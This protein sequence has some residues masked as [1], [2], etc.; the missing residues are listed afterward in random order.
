MT[1]QSTDQT[2]SYHALTK[3]AFEKDEWDHD[4]YGL[5][6]AVDANLKMSG[7]L[8]NRPSATNAPD[9]A[10]YEATDES[11]IYRNDPANGWVVNGFGTAS[12]PVPAAY[13]DSLT[14]S[15]TAGDAV[16]SF[17]TPTQAA[18]LTLQDVDGEF[19]FNTPLNVNGNDVWT[20]GNF[21]PSSKLSTTN[22]TSSG[23]FSHGGNFK[24]DFFRSADV[25]NAS[26]GE[27]IVSNGDGTFSMEGVAS[28]EAV[29]VADAPNGNIQTV[30]LENG[31]STE[32]S[33]TVP[34]GKSLTVYR[35]GCYN[36]SNSTAPTGLEVQLL[37]DD[38]TVIGSENTVD[39]RETTNGVAWLENTGSGPD[40]YKLR[41]YNGTGN[42]HEVGGFFGYIVE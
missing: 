8:A 39:S 31:E 14:V 29:E 22:P 17:D 28:N 16:A 21:D 15:D 27:A 9:N 32:I 37:A 11:L 23:T 35:W 40:V 7:T 2:T 10:W 36:I 41:V 13:I 1:H 30:E 20:A 26:Q 24:P 25:K 18:S 33:V 42:T 38:D 19:N 5:V 3:P 4:Y 6:D 34:S 12:A